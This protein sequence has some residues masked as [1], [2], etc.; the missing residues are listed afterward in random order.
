MHLTRVILFA[1]VIIP[2]ST[3]AAIV[4]FSGPVQLIAPPTFIMPGLDYGTPIN[5][6]TVWNERQGISISGVAMDMVNNFGI[7]T[8]AVAGTVSGLVD[9]HFLHYRH[10]TL[11]PVGG[12]VKFD[13]PII[14]VAFDHLTLDPSDAPLGALGSI[15]FQGWTRGMPT[16]GNDVFS[17]SGSSLKFNLVG[18]FAYSDT[19]QLRILTRPIPSPG[20]VALLAS[21][22]LA[23]VRRRRD[24]H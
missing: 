18:H 7:S 20:P 19:V 8:A 5:T 3:H 6:V 2:A 14:G 17:I 1:S 11:N 15:Y 21:G 4:G 9:S 23:I 10:T 13:N 22:G 24:P 12:H 16:W